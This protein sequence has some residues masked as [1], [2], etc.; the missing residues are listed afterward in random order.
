MTP[1]SSFTYSMEY[2]AY[3]E[4]SLPCLM[5]GE[6]RVELRYT[7]DILVIIKHF[8]SLIRQ[9]CLYACYRKITVT[10]INL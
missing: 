6:G 5:G 10:Y 1:T 2:D 8:L 9:F 7:N 4:F 3:I